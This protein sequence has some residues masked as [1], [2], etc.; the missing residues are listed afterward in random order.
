MMKNKSRNLFFKSE[1]TIL[2]KLIFK[3]L[4]LKT[5]L[6]N[7]QD[8]DVFG[9]HVTWMLFLNINF[10]KYT[11]MEI[12]DGPKPLTIYFLDGLLFES[13]ISK[14]RM[15]IL[16]LCAFPSK[17]D[18]NFNSNNNNNGAIYLVWMTYTMMTWKNCP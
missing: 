11:L 14:L 10:I 3:N 4:F 7:M 2:K 12:K 9:K 5:L 18:M 8:L 16:I 6:N 15:G 17:G 13:W 1:L